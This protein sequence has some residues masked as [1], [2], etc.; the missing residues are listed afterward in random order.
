MH[1]VVDAEG[2]AG[3]FWCDVDEG[4]PISLYACFSS[5]A[6]LISSSRSPRVFLFFPASQ[7]LLRD[8]LVPA[9]VTSISSH[10]P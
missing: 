1:V 5:I 7:G 2:R 3:G 8:A 4:Q 9:L 10:K 6:I